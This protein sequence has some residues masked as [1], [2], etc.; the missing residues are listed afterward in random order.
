MRK[1]VDANVVLRYMLH[2][3][4]DQ[5]PVAEQ[6]IREGAYLLPEVL[7]E[8]VYVLLGVYSVPRDEIASRMKLLVDEVQSERPE[9]LKSALEFFGSTKLDFVDCLLVAYHNHLGDNVTSF[10]RKLNRLL[11]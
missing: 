1:L 6:T 4:D 10:D 8:I 2:D 9:V 5:F 3:D 11:R 7:A